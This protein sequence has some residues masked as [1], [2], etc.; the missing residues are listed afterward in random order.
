MQKKLS[1]VQRVRLSRWADKLFARG[2][3]IRNGVAVSVHDNG[4]IV[5]R[6]FHCCS[7]G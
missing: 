6:V 3:H 2:C 7:R 5:E 4:I 1:Q